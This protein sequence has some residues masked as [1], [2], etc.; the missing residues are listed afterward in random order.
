[1]WKKPAKSTYRFFLTQLLVK[2]SAEFYIYI[3]IYIYIYVRIYEKN[4]TL[5]IMIYG[6]KFW[7]KKAKKTKKQ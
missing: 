6:G 3:Y 5:M 1:M 2:P 4:W 7:G